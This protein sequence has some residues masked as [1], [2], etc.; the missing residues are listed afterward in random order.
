[1]KDKIIPPSR[2]PER[3]V[4]ESDDLKMVFKS[5]RK[6]WNRSELSAGQNAIYTSA[7]ITICTTIDLPF[8]SITTL[9]NIWFSVLEA[10][11]QLET[12]NGLKIS[13]EDSTEEKKQ[14]F[15]N[16]F[17]IQYEKIKNGAVFDT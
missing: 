6:H 16:L 17:D 12:L 8:V 1:M 11:R 14:S 3:F 13:I 5:V 9:K 4:L 15:Q 10:L 7:M 2:M